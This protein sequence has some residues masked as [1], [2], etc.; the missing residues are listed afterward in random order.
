[1]CYVGDKIRKIKCPSIDRKANL[2]VLQK[3]ANNFCH[4]KALKYC[5]LNLK[6]I[7]NKIK[8]SCYMVN[9]SDIEKVSGCTCNQLACG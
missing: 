4:S 8:N 9:K 7:R 5:H 1:M 3:F 6:F 2:N